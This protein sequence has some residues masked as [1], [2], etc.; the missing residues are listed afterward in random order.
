MWVATL[1]DDEPTLI[2]LGKCIEISVEENAGSDM[3]EEDQSDSHVV[4]A[5]YYILNQR[6]EHEIYIGSEQACRDFLSSLMEKLNE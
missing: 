3:D 5:S 6:V 4:F 1:D 2:D